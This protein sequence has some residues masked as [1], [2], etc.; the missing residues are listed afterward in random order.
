MAKTFEFKIGH[1]NVGD[2]ILTVAATNEKQA[3]A[4]A[5]QHAEDRTEFE[6][7][8]GPNGEIVSKNP[9]YK[10]SVRKA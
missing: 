3:R 1:P 2:Y 6:V 5:E 4:I 7:E 8:Y 9:K 10:V